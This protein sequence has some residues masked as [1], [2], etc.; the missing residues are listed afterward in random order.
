MRKIIHILKMHFNKQ[1]KKEFAS[2]IRFA[3]LMTAS[4]ALWQ[5]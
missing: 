2:K 4:K 1:Y 3:R 5:D